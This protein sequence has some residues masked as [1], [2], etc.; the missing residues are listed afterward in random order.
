MKAEAIANVHRPASAIVDTAY[1]EHA[2]PNLPEGSRPHQ[3]HL[4]RAANRARQ[5][6]RP[7]EPRD[8]NFEVSL[9]TVIKYTNL[10]L[11]A[12]VLSFIAKQYI[13]FKKVENRNAFA[14]YQIFI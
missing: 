12:V 9:Y 2:D 14:A 10:H 1:T 6:L 8:L 5:K 11:K 7:E 4:V 13:E 3:G